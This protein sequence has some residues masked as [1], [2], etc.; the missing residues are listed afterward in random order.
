LDDGHRL[1]REQRQLGTTFNTESI[2]K[3]G[4][5]KLPKLAGLARQEWPQ[6]VETVETVE[7]IETR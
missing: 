7:T 4:A 3:A 5:A 6:L 2:R 1:A